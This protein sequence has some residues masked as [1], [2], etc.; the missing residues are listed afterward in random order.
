MN[1]NPSQLAGLLKNDQPSEEL[2]AHLDECDVCR[3]KLV[4]L[5]ADERVWNEVS[6]ALAEEDGATGDTRTVLVSL[7]PD[8][9]D[10][11]PIQADPVSLEF[12]ERPSHPEMLGRLGRYDIERLIGVGGMGIVLKAFDQEL[13]R[14]VA[15]K[16]LAPHLA[17]HGAARQRFAREA[18]SAA[19]VIH[20]NVVPIHCVDVSGKLPFIVMQFVAGESLQARVNREGPLAMEEVL[21][22]G[23]QVASGLS[24]A[25]A[26]GLVHR[27]VKP[28]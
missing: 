12:L 11:M 26:E 14:P 16:V 8:L 23:K 19:A 15:V 9:S 27:D 28:G 13:N 4:A 22:I 24:A 17:H 1:C 6:V 21:R 7:D 25:H 3:S 18:Q 2:S 20:E 10:D 5:A